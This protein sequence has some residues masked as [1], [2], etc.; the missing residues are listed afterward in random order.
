MTSYT[1]DLLTSCYNSLTI[2]F[3]QFFNYPLYIQFFNYPLYIQ[4][5]SILVI[6]HL[7]T[8]YTIFPVHS[9][10]FFLYLSSS[11]T[12]TLHSILAYPL[13]STLFAYIF[14]FYVS[15]FLYNLNLLFTLFSLHALPSSL[16]L[17][18]HLLLLNLVTLPIPS[19]LALLH[20]TFLTFLPNF[21]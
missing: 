1:L 21:N 6:S 17:P 18:L 20:L 9:I 13:H 14:L 10:L 12:L 7:F 11:F 2:Q 8:L 19:S 15:F 5:H 3:F 4:F 16:P